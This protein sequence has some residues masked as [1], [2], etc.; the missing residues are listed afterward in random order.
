MSNQLTTFFIEKANIKKCLLLSTLKN[1]ELKDL[2]WADNMVF[3]DSRTWKWSIYFRHIKQYIQ[4]VIKNNGI[5]KTEYRFGKYNYDGRLYALNGMGLQSIQGNL[6]NYISGEYYNDIDIVNAHPSIL[7]FLCDKYNIPSV[8]LKR[9]VD[10]RSDILG[11]ENLNKLDFLKAINTD[12]N[13]QK[14]NKQFYNSFIVEIEN[15]KEVIN[16]H[17][18]D[19]GITISNTNDNNPKSS[20]I[21]KILC[22][23]E[24]DI[25]QKAIQYFKPENVG[26]PMFDGFLLNKEI[27]INLEE[28]NDLFKDYKYISFIEK[29][30]TSDIVIE[31]AE[32]IQDSYEYE[33]VKKELEKQYFR[34]DNP[35]TYWKK[36]RCEDDSFTYKQITKDSLKD[37]CEEFKIITSDCKLVSIYRTWIADTDKKKYDNIVFN[38]YGLYN[39]C[40]SHSY[41]TFNG[42][43]INKI[44]DYE[45]EVDINNFKRFMR[46]LCNEYN[47]PSDEITQY[48]IKY[49]AHM[50]QF[51]NERPDTIIIFKGWTGAGKDTFYTILQR[52]LGMEH[53]GNVDNLDE[54]F[55]TFTNVLNNKICIFM[56]E[57]EGNDTVKIQE[58]LKA[59][60]TKEYN[61]INN[62]NE[63]VIYQ[64]NFIRYFGASNG[65]N[66]FNIQI[67]D[68]RTK[69]IKTGFE[70]ITRTSNK[71]KREDNV[72]FFN[73]L[74]E[75][76]ENPKWLMCVY[77]YLMSIDLSNFNVKTET[78][79][80]E[81]YLLAKSKNVNTIYKFLQYIIDYDIINDNDVFKQKQTDRESIHYITFKDFKELYTEYQEENFPDQLFKYKDLYIK[82]ILS[83][84]NDS[85][86][87]PKKMKYSRDGSVIRETLMGFK[88]D[89]VKSFLY[90]YVYY[91]N[92]K[93][94]EEDLGII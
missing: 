60:V 79:Q 80:T 94:E 70:L 9:Y 26:V 16:S 85:Y 89:R 63:K 42:F 62:K 15:I 29:N 68:R 17:I 19:E 20:S 27:N 34:V 40:P 32:F 36:S 67:N 46:C 21:N 73:N 39:T 51:P 86:L 71:N 74:Y 93:D 54:I 6:R 18:L 37:A 23:Y 10:N 78:L 77:K 43:R 31:D 76:I 49:I 81:E 41:N 61:T 90:D 56:N 92:N 11:D 2:F 53:I 45:E 87:L 22:K 44:Q 84:M 28:L 30:T 48:L 5:I 13:K 47:K 69:L 50:F 25:I 14:R 59:M 88:F 72:N 38:P 82:Q 8:Y 1:T 64:K 55:G 65:M 3:K 91:D 75:C 66:P 35:F 12:N 57:L 58:R 7:L 52:L 4:T 33:D 83:N 24:N